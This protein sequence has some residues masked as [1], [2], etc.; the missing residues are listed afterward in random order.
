MAG[1]QRKR[2]R[3]RSSSLTEQV[4]LFGN[5]EAPGK[6][7]P[8]LP[9]QPAVRCPRLPGETL[10]TTTACHRFLST[11]NV[12]FI[13]YALGPPYKWQKGVTC[14]R[15]AVIGR[16]S[17][18]APRLRLSRCYKGGLLLYQAR[19]WTD[20]RLIV[21][22]GYPS[23]SIGGIEIANIINLSMVDLQRHTL[24]I[25]RLLA[26]SDGLLWILW[27]KGAL[28][29]S[30]CRELRITWHTQTMLHEHK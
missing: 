8:H 23:L 13:S 4:A 7:S 3:R 5:R 27:P 21:P 28:A 18:I 6:F 17:W 22:Q 2:E 19:M 14:W 30:S 25:S 29:W 11:L 16:H 26:W 24:W 9:P 15:E 20:T 10:S 12:L 1:G